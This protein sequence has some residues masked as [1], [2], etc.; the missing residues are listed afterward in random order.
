MLNNNSVKCWLT[1][2]NRYGANVVTVITNS[3]VVVIGV[4]DLI[5]LEEKHVFSTTLCD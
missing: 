1:C 2:I 5:T 4:V 3:N